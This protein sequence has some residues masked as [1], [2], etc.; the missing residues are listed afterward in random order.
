MK[1]KRFGEDWNEEEEV[2]KEFG[3]MNTC[4]R[5]R[6]ESQDKNETGQFRRTLSRSEKLRYKKK[7]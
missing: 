5:C 2:W 7:M 6:N 1:R 4:R 3:R